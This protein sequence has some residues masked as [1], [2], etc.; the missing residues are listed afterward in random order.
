MRS[1]VNLSLDG[2]STVQ[3]LCLCRLSYSRTFYCTH[4]VFVWFQD[5]SNLMSCTFHSS[6][7]PGW[8]KWRQ[9]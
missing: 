2:G 6:T 7:G 1:S 8:Q 3:Y 4:V 5:R 9:S